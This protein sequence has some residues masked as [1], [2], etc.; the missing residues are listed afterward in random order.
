MRYQLIGIVLVFVGTC[1][2]APSK[3]VDDGLSCYVSRGSENLEDLNRN[4]D[5][6]EN[7][8]FCRSKKSACFAYTGFG[9]GETYPFDPNHGT[10]NE[11]TNVANETYRFF[12]TYNETTY[13]ETELNDDGETVCEGHGLSQTECEAIGCC[14]FDDNPVGCYSSVGQNQCFKTT[15]H[16]DDTNVCKE[17]QFA[18]SS[19]KE[20]SG[21]ITQRYLCDGDDDCQDGS[22]ERLDY[23]QARWSTEEYGR[24]GCLGEEFR[25][26]QPLGDFFETFYNYRNEFTDQFFSKGKGKINVALS[27]SQLTAMVSTNFLA[28][29]RNVLQRDPLDVKADLFIKIEDITI[30]LKLTGDFGAAYNAF[31]ILNDRP[32]YRLSFDTVLDAFDGSFGIVEQSIIGDL[33]AMYKKVS[34]F[35]KW[36][37]TTLSQSRREPVWTTYRGDKINAEVMLKLDVGADN[38]A[39]VNF[40]GEVTE[41]FRAFVSKGYFSSLNGN[42]EFCEEEQK[43]KRL[44]VCGTDNCN[45]FEPTEWKASL[46]ARPCPAGKWK[47]GIGGCQDCQCSKSG[48]TSNECNQETG[49]C[50]CKPGLINKKCDKCPPKSIRYVKN[51]IETPRDLNE[52][53]EDCLFCVSQDIESDRPEWLNQFDYDEGCFSCLSIQECK[54]FEQKGCPAA[55]LNY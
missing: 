25:S 38:T 18:C 21:C 52:N 4:K 40:K 51:D 33:G 7:S 24:F 12:N 42:V 35:A 9:A 11:A 14:H 37:Y 45:S 26:Q 32:W 10:V 36:I 54:T 47:N 31:L 27:G 22:D 5:N 17:W 28:A 16:I 15:T 2:T 20:G 53:Q 8:K 41:A 39:D 34:P 55:C 13:N 1:K 50:N 48:S 46:L 19:A 44:V 3:T 43:C 30:K 29:M 49:Q 23:C 6:P